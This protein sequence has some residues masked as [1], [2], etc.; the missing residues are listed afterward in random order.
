MKSFPA[1]STNCSKSFSGGQ[2]GGSFTRSFLGIFNI[3]AH[4]YIRISLLTTDCS[5][6]SWR[7]IPVV[8]YPMKI[9]WMYVSGRLVTSRH[10]DG[11][12]VQHGTIISNNLTVAS[13]EF[14]H[15]SSTPTTSRHG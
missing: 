5:T 13:T 8:F 1:L 10:R 9:L 15:S 12:S 3:S 4:K 11:T 6:F 14:S 7:T 2:D